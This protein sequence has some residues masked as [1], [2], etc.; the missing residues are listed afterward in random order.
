[1]LISIIIPIFNNSQ[2]L[3]RT[4]TSVLNQGL[5]QNNYEIILVNDGSTD[6]SLEI[7]KEYA[8]KN[9]SI[10]VISQ[11]NQG[12]ASARNYGIKAAQGDFI[13]FMDA[14]DYLMPYSLKYIYDHNYIKDIDILIFSSISIPNF[15]DNHYPCDSIDG[16]IDYEI[17]GE[18]F[19]R[20]GLINCFV[21]NQIIRSSFIREHHLSFEPISISEDVLF[22]IEAYNLNPKIR[23]ITSK[24][25]RYIS[26]THC[27]QLTKRRTPKDTRKQVKAYLTVFDK[28]TIIIRKKES[29]NKALQ[30]FAHKQFIPFTSRLL[31]S[32]MSRKELKEIRKKLSKSALFQRPSSKDNIQYRFAY[33]IVHD[34]ISFPLLR[35]IYKKIFIPYILPHINRN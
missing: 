6:N 4:L 7:C 25:Y 13:Y 21:W 35:F 2:V 14:D 22:N 28:L 26:Y 15:D 34:N 18:D 29:L 17:Y 5:S 3:H 23:R 12:V 1:M 24:L 8:N 31:S 19:I 16:D 27:E 10:K 20:Q 30:Y 32:N 33:Y 9:P 11:P